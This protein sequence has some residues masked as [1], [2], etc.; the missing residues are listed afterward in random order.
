MMSDIYIKNFEATGKKI[1]LD[2]KQTIVHVPMTMKTTRDI[3]DFRDTARYVGLL[4][5]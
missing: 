3:L 1:K 2:T 4:V 5:L